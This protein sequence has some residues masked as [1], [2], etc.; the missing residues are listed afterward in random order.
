MNNCWNNFKQFKTIVETIL[1][2]LKQLLKQFWT[3]LNNCWNNFEQLWTIL[4][5]RKWSRTTKPFENTQYIYYIML[6]D[7]TILNYPFEGLPR[8]A[9]IKR[10][11]DIRGSVCVFGGNK[12]WCRSLLQISIHWT[13]Q[14]KFQALKSIHYS[15]P[16]WQC[17]LGK[18]SWYKKYIII[19]G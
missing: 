19:M 16:K 8:F 4:R 5:F 3:I 11:Y 7:Y 9:K 12:N 14:S 10:I 1:N 15:H 17:W 2:N 6:W 13:L 18:A